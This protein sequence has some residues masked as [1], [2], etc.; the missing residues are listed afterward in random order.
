MA[1]RKI[2]P[3]EHDKIGLI[4]VAVMAR[5]KIGAECAAVSG[6]GR[7]HAETAVGVD[8]GCADKAFHQLVGDLIIFR[9]NLTRD[10]KRHA[11]GAVLFNRLDKP[12]R[13]MRKRCVPCDAGA[14]DAG[15]KQA[16]FK[17]QR[18]A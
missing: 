8:I 5:H 14:V 7:G 11:F 2:G 6:D 13:H 18:F 9:Q 16:I 4:E 15:V 10:I 12:L 17:R 3:D 1:P